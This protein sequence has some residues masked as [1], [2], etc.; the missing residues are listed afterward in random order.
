MSSAAIPVALPLKVGSYNCGELYQLV[1]CFDNNGFPNP[2]LIVPVEQE[3]KIDNR[4]RR[5]TYESEKLFID[6]R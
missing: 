2:I 3:G 1:A 4:Q 6:R 5:L